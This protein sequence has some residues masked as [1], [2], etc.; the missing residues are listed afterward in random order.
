MN[1]NRIKLIFAIAGIYDFVIG[2]AVLFFHRSLFE[3]FNA[4]PVGHPSYAQFPSLLVVIFGAMLFQVSRDPVRYRAFM[5][6]GIALKAAFVGDALWCYAT[7]GLPLMW[8]PVAIIDLAFFGLFIAAWTS[9][10][11]AQ[12]AA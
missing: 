1:L 3:L 5:P 11:K 6:Y 4:P 10:S 2:G 9:V 8:A 12:A 7:S